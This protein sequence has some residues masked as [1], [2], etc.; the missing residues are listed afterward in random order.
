MTEMEL[1]IAL[2]EAARSLGSAKAAAAQ[3]DW[4]KAEQALVA[5]QERNATLLREIGLKLLTEFRDEDAIRGREATVAARGMDK[6]LAA[7]SPNQSQV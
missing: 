4:V 5:A 2:H 3:G 6:A 1:R 7:G